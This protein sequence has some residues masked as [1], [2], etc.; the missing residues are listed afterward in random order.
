[1]PTVAEMIQAILAHGIS[2]EDIAQRL[3]RSVQAVY[4]WQ[5]GRVP[6][7][8]RATRDRI[9]EL[10]R[11][12]AGGGTG[13]VATA[14]T[15]AAP[16][17]AADDPPAGVPAPGGMIAASTPDDTVPLPDR[18]TEPPPRTADEAFRFIH[19]ADLHI[20]S[21]LKGLRK[22]DPRYAEWIR[23]ATRRSFIRLVDMAIENQV[24]FIVIAGDLYDGDWKSADTG[25]FLNRQLKRLADAGIPVFAI[26]GNHDALSVVTRSVK[27]PDA[28]RCFGNAA[29]SV[30]IP[31]L[32]VVIHG[33]SFGARYEG[34]DFV[35][36]YPPPVAG[37]FNIG[38]LHTSLTGAVGHAEYA[39]CSP[40]QLAAIG[41][42]YWALGHVHVPRVMQ[43]NPH[44]V[45]P[46]NIQGRDIGE[47]GPRGCFV[48]TVDQAR[49]P[50][51]HFVALDDV[52][53]S[54]IEVAVDAIEVETPEDVIE[55]AIE[56]IEGAMP[57]DERL[58][59]CRVVLK[60]ATQLHAKLVSRGGSL[61]EEVANS[62]GS[63]LER[64]C[65]EEVTVETT[66][67]E[68]ATRVPEADGRAIALLGEEF[69]RLE[70]TAITTLLQESSD[71]KKLFDDLRVLD[72]VQAGRRSELQQPESWQ[73][74]VKE[75]R[76]LLEAELGGSVS[77]QETA[78]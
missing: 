26:T 22:I 10:Y 5:T 75:A 65:L 29:E 64:V 51:P 6:N 7:P 70:D 40:A 18:H 58:L 23:A 54:R 13:F 2:K 34:A 19:C 78:S 33:R 37:S 44:I 35:A 62:A 1:M 69:A 57:N 46:G 11:S 24:D 59:A 47:T 30:E 67:P 74:F 31:D 32:G 9:E 28:A 77:R 66:D 72:S 3:G 53:W 41:Y 60:G 68:S 71:L 45:Y 25:I 48:V 21:P 38:L 17:E 43:T 56:A 52:R 76:Q 73:D 61:R 36:G 50:S 49:N 12:V 42:D 39:P 8:H 20:D 55:A 14:A 27:W 4:S 15:H 63:Q 16:N